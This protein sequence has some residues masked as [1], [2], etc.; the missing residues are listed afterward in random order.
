MP[1]QSEAYKKASEEQKQAKQAHP[2]QHRRLFEIM[3][4]YEKKLERPKIDETKHALLEQ[5]KLKIKHKPN[6]KWYL[7]DKDTGSAGEDQAGDANEGENRAEINPRA[8]GNKYLQQAKMISARYP[9]KSSP[10]SS[11]NQTVDN[12]PKQAGNEAKTSHGKSLQK[13]TTNSY[14]SEA[15]IRRDYL[16]EMRLANANTAN[17][18]QTS[19]EMHKSLK[20]TKHWEKFLRNENLT[21]QEKAERI[22][23]EA[24]KL[25]EMA[26]RKEMLS[27]VKPHDAANAQEDE[28]IDQIYINA[29]KAKLAILEKE[30]PVQK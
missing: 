13:L 23:L 15:V 6:F 30:Q 5:Q 3:K 25:E 24:E 2:E 19:S 21:D 17:Q 9:R 1:Y 4:E 29:I 20:A 26:R 22:L 18:N 7:K 12:I 14:K 10:Q 11:Q 16:K 28:E 27:K 8:L